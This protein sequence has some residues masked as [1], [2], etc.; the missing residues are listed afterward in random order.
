MSKPAP[1][2][3]VV[4]VPHASLVVPGDVAADLLLNASE[5]EHELLVMT[6]RYTDELFAMPP[7]LATT[8]AFP[9]SRLVVDPERFTD[10]TQEPMA[11]KGMG[12]IYTRTA[13]GQPL[14]GIPFPA[15]RERLLA[16]FY[17]P[18]H[19]AL[20]T[21]VAVALATHGGCLLVDGH[22]FP[23]RPLP[24]ED[25]Q[26]ADRPDICIGTDPS[27][28]PAWLRD[29]AVRAFEDQ[30]WRVAVDRP[31]SGAL[32]PMAFYRKD[33][34]VRAIMVEVRRDL[35][36]DESSGARLPRFDEVWGRILG[37]LGVVAAADASRG[38]GG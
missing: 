13:G 24:Y 19:A 6:D 30:G 33:V 29:I 23:A 25:D 22:S 4:H 9:V 12:V 2:A 5:I 36:M 37:A 27:H 26:E 34:R 7:S 15:E 20:T 28:T 31:F 17:E 38:R 11:M 32:V 8:V 21:A 35:Y 14:R 16:R 18:H 3:L 10:D 1:A